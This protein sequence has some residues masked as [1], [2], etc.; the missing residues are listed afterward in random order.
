MLDRGLGHEEGAGQVDRDDLLPVLVGHLG[1]GPV[2]RDAGVV[3]QDVDPA[4][5]VDH[6]VQDPAAVVR[7]A[8]VALVHGDPLAGEVG[9]GGGEE[10]LRGFGAAPVARRDVG[11]LAGQFTADGGADAAGPSGDQG[12]PVLD[13]ARPD[14]SG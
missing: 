4:V 7:A 5:L 12:H 13:Q 6:L 3:D 2:D 11:A 9:H 8:D 1:H 10:L 14:P